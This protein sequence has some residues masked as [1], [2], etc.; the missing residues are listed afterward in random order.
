VCLGIPGQFVE[1]VAGYEDQLAVVDVVGGRRQVN[2]GM[3]ADESLEPGDWVL[4]HVGF[5]VE[6][7][8]EETAQQ[9]RAGLELMGRPREFE[10]EDRS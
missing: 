7:V 6:K 3:L 4:I 9:A 1:R 8:D 10:R 5:A 2:V